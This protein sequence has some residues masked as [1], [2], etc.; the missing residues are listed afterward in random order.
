MV[1]LGF[2]QTWGGLRCL[3]SFLD[4]AHGRRQRTV[5]IER[6]ATSLFTLRLHVF[7]PPDTSHHCFLAQS[8]WS[9]HEM[10]R[11]ACWRLHPQMHS[12]SRLHL[13]SRI[14]RNRGSALPSL[15]WHSP[16]T[17]AR[18]IRSMATM[19]NLPCLLH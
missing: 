19:T 3:C 7:M 11:A 14:C 5:S 8:P 10:K 17:C 18:W 2:Q 1:K 4:F 12:S 9:H 13:F 16:P 15:I 6:I